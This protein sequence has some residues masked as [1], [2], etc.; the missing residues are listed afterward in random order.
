VDHVLADQLIENIVIKADAFA[1]AG[2]FDVLEEIDYGIAGVTY[3]AV[4][5][6]SND[7]LE[8]FLPPSAIARVRDRHYLLHKIIEFRLST[9]MALDAA[10]T[11]DLASCAGAPVERNV[12]KTAATVRVLASMGASK[13]V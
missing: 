3:R 7:L 12:T 4:P 10:A 11:I 8:L 2:A 9:P 5:D 6:P 13:S 1:S